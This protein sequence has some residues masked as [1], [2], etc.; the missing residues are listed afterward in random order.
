MKA[1]AAAGLD[2]NLRWIEFR[3]SRVSKRKIHEGELAIYG[4]AWRDGYG[5]LGLHDI[6]CRY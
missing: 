3:F 5:V 6:Y 1:A 4:R 2:I